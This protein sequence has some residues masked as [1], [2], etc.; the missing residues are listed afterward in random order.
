MNE[1][2]REE[3]PCLEVLIGLPR[4][5]FACI[6]ETLCESRVKLHFLNDNLWRLEEL[7]F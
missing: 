4:C 1:K 3:I 6:R 5:R 7:G 2:G